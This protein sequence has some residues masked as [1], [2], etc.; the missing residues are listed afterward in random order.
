MDQFFSCMLCAFWAN[1]N[2]TLYEEIHL[3]KIA[4]IQKLDH[5]QV[6]SLTLS[7]PTRMP[8][9]KTKVLATVAGTLQLAWAPPWGEMEEMGRAGGQA[10]AMRSDPRGTCS[11]RCYYR[12]TPVSSQLLYLVWVSMPSPILPSSHGCNKKPLNCS[13]V[14][15]WSLIIV[16]PNYC[17]FVEL[18]VDWLPRWGRCGVGRGQRL[19]GSDQNFIKNCLGICILIKFY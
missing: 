14:K 7:L 8:S 4:H 3:Q 9:L 5:C 19:P 2:I 10:Q 11:T 13:S 1:R 16:D 17:H 12:L 15:L 6:L 18:V